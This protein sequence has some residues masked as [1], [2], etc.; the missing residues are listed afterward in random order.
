[1]MWQFCF[2]AA[3]LLEESYEAEIARLWKD[4]RGHVL[5]RLTYVSNGLLRWFKRIRHEKRNSLA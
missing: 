4:S 1:M 3:W 2:E 5:S